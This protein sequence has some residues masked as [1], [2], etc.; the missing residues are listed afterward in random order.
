MIGVLMG[1]ENTDHIAGLQPQAGETSLGLTP[2]ESTVDQE[3][4]RATTDRIATVR[5]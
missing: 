5:S 1:D 3:H 4:P 2:T